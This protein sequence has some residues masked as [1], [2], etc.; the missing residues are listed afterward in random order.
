MEKTMQEEN[1]AEDIELELEVPEEEVDVREADVDANAAD[2]LSLVPNTEETEEIK[3]PEDRVQEYLGSDPE[4]Q[5]YGDGVQKRIN[6]LT[7]QREEAKRRE[8]AAVQYAQQV[9]AQ[10]QGLQAQAQQVTSQRDEQLMDEYGNRINAELE[11]AK[12]RYKEAYESGDADLIVEANKELSALAVEQDKV[13][14][15]AARRPAPGQ[16]PEAQAQQYYQQQPAQQQAPQ[17]NPPRPDE[18]AESWATENTWFGEDE[19]MTH[20]ALG[21]HRKMVE[22]EGIDPH[23]NEYYEKIDGY[24]RSNF[25]HKFDN[26]ANSGTVNNNSPVQTVAPAGRTAGGKSGRKVKLTASQVAIAKRLNV[27]LTEYAKYV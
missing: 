8:E 17:Y 5:E 3:S 26:T 11:T 18:K 6:K 22:E 19:A 15:R 1:V 27:P 4:L 9:Q 20:S 21:Y 10:M 7:Y 23:S 24:M 2:Q 12:Q 16:S 13:K 14:R 25:P